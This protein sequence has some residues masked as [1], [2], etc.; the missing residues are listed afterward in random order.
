MYAYGNP[1]FY[2]DPNG[3][4]VCFGLCIAGAVLIGGAVI[5]YFYDLDEASQDISNA[6]KE[7]NPTSTPGILAAVAAETFNT[8]VTGAL[9]ALPTVGEQTGEFLANE[10]RTLADAPILGDIGTNLGVSSAAFAENPSFETGV[11]AFGAVSASFLTV[12]VPVTGPKTIKE[13]RSGPGVNV[14]SETQALNRIKENNLKSKD[15]HERINQRGKDSQNPQRK[16]DAN[17]GKGNQSSS[18]ST[19]GDLNKAARASF[20]TN[21][22]SSWNGFQRATAGQ[23]KSRTEAAFAWKV[24]KEASQSN[25][26]LVI[27]RQP[28]TKAAELAGFQRLNLK[29]G[30]T[31]AVNKAW[32]QG[33]IDFG[34]PLRLASS[35]KKSNLLN[36][37]GAERPYTVFRDELHQL[38]DAGYTIRGGWALPPK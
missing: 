5:D 9:N 38:K 17:N 2:T 16:N 10:N 33:A 21:G 31:S 15:L 29:T 28:D 8:V 34:R 26:P 23:F 25:R 14:K 12:V 3:R 13:S 36:P 27:G 24:Y 32:V 6:I 30:W 22:I 11:Q 19:V 7:T 1:L 4:A 20:T 35:V 37:P 18:S